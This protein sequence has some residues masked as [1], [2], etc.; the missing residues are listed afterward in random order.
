[1]GGAVVA[2]GFA[3]VD[4][5]LGR[6]VFRAI[7]CATAFVTL[8]AVWAAWDSATPWDGSTSLAALLMFGAGAVIAGFVTRWCFAS[9]RTFGDFMAVV[10]GDESDTAMGDRRPR[11]AEAR[12]LKPR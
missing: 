11:A 10:G 5:F 4:G 3:R 8:A 9:E 2:N 1:M 7:G 12:S 6:L